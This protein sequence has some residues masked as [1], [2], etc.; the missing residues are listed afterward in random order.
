MR[1][2]CI[3]MVEISKSKASLIASLSSS[4]MRSRHR[5]FVAEGEKCALDTVGSFPLVNIVATPDW[6]SRHPEV[7]KLHNDILLV[8]P[9]NV[10]AKISSLS[11]PPEVLALFRMPDDDAAELPDPS[12]K[13]SLLLDG[14]RDPGNMGTIIRTADWFGFDT[15]F[16]SPDCVDIF[17]PKTIQSTMGSLRR[18]SVVAT[19]LCALVRAHASM[20]VYGLLLDGRDIYSTPLQGEGF[21]VM[22]NE[23]KGLSR[24]MRELVTDPLLIPPFRGDSHGESLNVAVATAITLSVFRH[25]LVE[26]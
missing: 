12:G 1:V 3:R 22:G 5:M 17:N 6:I 26:I 25:P 20:P 4:K 14:V 8:A 2:E 10:M 7:T 13:L 19:D 21:I 9:Q 15:V 24:E 23:G 18:V 11:T 16:I